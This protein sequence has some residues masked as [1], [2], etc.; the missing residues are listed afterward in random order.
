MGGICHPC[1]P[2]KPSPLVPAPA[3][4][5]QPCPA[6]SGLPSTFSPLSWISRH[7]TADQ[8]TCH[9][10]KTFSTPL[11]KIPFFTSPFPPAL[12][13]LFFISSVHNALFSKQLPLGTHGASPQCSW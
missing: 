7:Y 8:S 2:P 6:T 11:L 3:E 9:K 13:L 10:H 4:L 12:T 1:L 5:P